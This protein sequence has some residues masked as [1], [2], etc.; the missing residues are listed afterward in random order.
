[1][2]LFT[3]GTR[4]TELPGGPVQGTAG[5]IAKHARVPVQTVFIET[6]S[7]FLGKG[8]SV[9]W[10]P[11]MPITYRIRLGKRLIRRGTPRNL[12]ANSSSTSSPNWR[13]RS[14]PIFL[15]RRRRPEPGLFSFFAQVSCR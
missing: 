7:G 11:K 6:N 14:Y 9:L 8:W 2:L 5:L 12:R 15:S 13:M 3:E 4:T 10:R 1:L